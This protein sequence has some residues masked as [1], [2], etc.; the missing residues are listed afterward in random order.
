MAYLSKPTD[1]EEARDER[2][3]S[4]ISECSDLYTYNL[5]H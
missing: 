1:Q 3:N 4:P 2:R 5:H